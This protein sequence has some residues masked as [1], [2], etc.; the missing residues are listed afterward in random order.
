MS[1]RV[2]YA[3]K[4]GDIEETQA[5]NV[6]GDNISVDDAMVKLKLCLNRMIKDSNQ[7]LKS[8]C[9]GGP[10][11]VPE[12]YWLEAGLV[13]HPHERLFGFGLQTSHGAQKAFQIIIEAHIL[14]HLF[15]GGHK[16]RNARGFKPRLS[17]GR[18]MP[19]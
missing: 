10:G 11:L 12:P 4:T 14:K 7:K 5:G 2:L 9:Y 8:I 13:F 18:P 6:R 16:N 19:A 17:K 3:R 1:D 15:F